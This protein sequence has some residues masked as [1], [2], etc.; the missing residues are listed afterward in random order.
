MRREGDAQPRAP[1]ADGTHQ[2]GRAGRAHLVLQGGAQPPGQPAGHEDLRPGEGD[3]LPGLRGRG[4]RGHRTRG[5][6]EPH[7]GRLPQGRRRARQRL[8]GPDGRRGDQ[9]ASR[10]PRP[11]GPQRRPAQRPGEHAQQAEDQGPLQAAQDRRADPPLREPAGV[12]GDGRDPR[13]PAGPAPPGAAG[14]RELRH[15]RP[16]RPVPAHHQP[17]QP[18]QEADGPQRARGD[19]PQRE[20]DAAA[21]RGRAVRQR[22]LPSARAGLQQP[23]AEVADGH[24]QGQAGPLPREPAGQ[25]RGLLGALGD[26]G[27]PRVA[28]APVRPAQEDRPG[29]VPAVHHPQA[30]GARAGR[31][32]QERQED[33]GTA[34]PGGVGHPRRGDR[35]APGAAQPG[36]HAAPHGHPGLRAD[37]GRGQCHQGAPAGVLGLQCRLRRRPDGR[38]PA[39][40]GRGPGRGPHPDAGHAQHLQPRERRPDHL[41]LAGHRAG[42][43]LHHVAARGR[44]EGPGQVPVLQG[45]D[46]GPA[47]L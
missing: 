3:L 14:E 8:Q 12:D 45:P 30:E 33:A 10:P 34:R 9:G 2:P 46:R 18:P 4:P 7:R 13:H 16:Q 19:H 36:P 28:P 47:G 11:G 6:P 15:Q 25:A 24:D 5:A 26:R 44:G 20:A 29:A 31:H 37:P 43:V 32:H 17:Q 35:P 22:P 21:V 1:Q 40:V 39:P 42:R 38:A 27:R 41:A 23:A